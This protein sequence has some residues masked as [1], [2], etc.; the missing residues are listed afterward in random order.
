MAAESEELFWTYL[1]NIGVFPQDATEEEQY[2]QAM[3]VATTLLSD[4]QLNMLEYALT[5]RYFSPRYC[6]SPIF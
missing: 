1:E 3:Q 2:K 4:V 5:M 6:I